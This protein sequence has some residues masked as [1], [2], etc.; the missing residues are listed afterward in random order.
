[1]IIRSIKRTED[2][3]SA[4]SVRNILPIF[5]D[6]PMSIDLIKEYQYQHRTWSS[7]HYLAIV[8]H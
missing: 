2:K 3:N 4:K 1:M 5:R 6:N 7:G 8:G